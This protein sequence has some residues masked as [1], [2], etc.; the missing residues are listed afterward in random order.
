MSAYYIGQLFGLTKERQIEKLKAVIELHNGSIIDV[1]KEWGC[2]RQYVYKAVND[3]GLREFVMRV[4]SADYVP[5]W[6]ARTI[7]VF[8]EELSK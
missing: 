2:Y 4:R 3:L 6:C 7:E 5:S 8:K 1:A